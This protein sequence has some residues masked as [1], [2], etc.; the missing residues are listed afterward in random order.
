[1]ERE[2]RGVYEPAWTAGAPHDAY[3]PAPLPPQPA[4]D[5]STIL[6]AFGQ[7][8]AELV[9][10]DTLAER[11]PNR[12]LLVYTYVRRE[13]VLSSQIEGTRTTL[14]ELLRH[15]LS[16]APGQPIDDVTE[17][18][19]YVQA[20]SYGIAQTR[21][22]ALPLDNQL[23]C[24]LHGILLKSGRGASLH[25][26]RF[27]DAAVWIGGPHPRLARHVPPRYERVGECMAALE[28]F[29]G[30]RS[31]DIPPLL[32]AGL[33]HVQ[34]ETIHPF[35]DG[36]GRVG[37]ML[38]TLMLCS[39]GLMRHPVLYLSLFLRA[40]RE[41]YFDELNHVRETGDWERWLKFFLDGVAI[42][43]RD[44]RQTAQ[45]LTDQIDADRRALETVDRIGSAALQTFT[46]F[47]RRPLLSISAVQELSG[48]SYTGARSGVRLLEQQGII[49]EITG[50]RRDRIYAYQGCLEI[51]NRE[52]D[53]FQLVLGTDSATNKP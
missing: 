53:R 10:L 14:N 2:D 44:G 18:S 3:L 48:L 11:L 13:A 46:A 29:I 19:N 5:G 6:P 40:W 1:M 17:V 43:A 30:D 28:E 7:A 45:A 24:E 26:G 25:P 15:E 9:A 12:D 41:V 31:P 23:I 16:E 50:R 42:A 33:A 20:L 51:L 36:N 49:R 21:D 38:I 47:T 8:T 37:R 32:R 4:L 27:R 22:A 52:V 34:F 39:T 35:L